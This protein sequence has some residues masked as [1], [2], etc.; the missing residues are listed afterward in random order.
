M[1]VGNE[2]WRAL[3]AS[4]VCGAGGPPVSLS[5]GDMRVGPLPVRPQREPADMPALIVSIKSLALL[6]KMLSA[7]R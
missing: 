7:R 2:K 1:K 3:A 5:G 4:A 6:L